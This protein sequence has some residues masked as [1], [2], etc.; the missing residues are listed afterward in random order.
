VDTGSGMTPAQLE[1]VRRPLRSSRRDGTGL[2]LKIAR[3]IV[4]TH[5]GEMER[6]SSR[7]VGATVLIRLPAG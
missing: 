5:N 6:R 4:A 2:G 3:R 1:N 7:G